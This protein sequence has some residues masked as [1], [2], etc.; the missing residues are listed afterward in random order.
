PAVPTRRS[1]DLVGL[2]RETGGFGGDRRG[3]A[4]AAWRRL[5]EALADQRPL[6]LVLEDLH[7]AD[8]GLLDFVD[9]LVDWLS[10]VPLLVVCSARP[11]L[12]ERRRGWGGG[13]LNASMI[14]LA[15]LSSEQTAV[16]ISQVLERSVLPAEIQQALLDRSEGNP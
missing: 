1:S 10:G 7:W 5:F 6:V 8:E 15:P 3:E 4:F 2:D 14:G 12:L 11:E 16:L 13:K 9:E